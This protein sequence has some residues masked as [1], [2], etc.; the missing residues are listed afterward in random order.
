MLLLLGTTFELKGR[1]SYLLLFCNP[2]KY[3]KSIG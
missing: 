3:T 1:V 2:A